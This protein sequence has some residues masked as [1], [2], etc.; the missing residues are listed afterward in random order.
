MC[1]SSVWL[2]VG[3]FGRLSARASCPAPASTVDDG[4]TRDWRIYLD[5]CAVWILCAGCNWCGIPCAEL[6]TAAGIFY[7]A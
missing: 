7:D 4:G 5:T 6:N 1:A 2:Y 3:T